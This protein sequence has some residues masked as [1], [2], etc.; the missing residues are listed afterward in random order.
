MSVN[1][2][3]L[4]GAQ[5]YFEHQY[6]PYIGGA[7]LLT[8]ALV[9]FYATDISRVLK[10]KTG[11]L[12]VDKLFSEYPF[13]AHRLSFWS[14]TKVWRCTNF[15]PT[16]GHS[17]HPLHG[18]VPVPSLPPCGPLT[19]P[20]QKPPYGDRISPKVRPFVSCVLWRHPRNAS[21]SQNHFSRVQLKLPALAF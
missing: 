12:A 16:G 4:K 8:G 11:L 5:E 18:W 6:V 14:S 15:W 3:L 1:E 13:S 10:V 2:R 9:W 17:C 20:N 7:S 21:D 19:S